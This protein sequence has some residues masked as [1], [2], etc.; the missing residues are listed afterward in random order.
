MAIACRG[1]FT[2][3]ALPLGPLLSSPW[4]YSC[5]TRPMVLRWD[6]DVFAIV[7]PPDVPPC[8]RTVRR[9]LGCIDD[10]RLSRRRRLHRSTA[11]GIAACTHRHEAAARAAVG[12]R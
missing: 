2:L 3:P 5:I 11:R 6:I 9:R 1:F 4:V 12:L 8:L 10:H 7:I